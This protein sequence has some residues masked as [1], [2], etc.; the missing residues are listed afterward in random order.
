MIKNHADFKRQLSTKGTRLTTLALANGMV[1]GRIKIG[2]T[3]HIR[4]ADTTGV[5]LITDEELGKTT[6]GSFLGFDKASD[7][8]FEGDIATNTK[9]GYSYRVLLPNEKEAT[10]E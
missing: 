1:E 10:N 7:W 9:F 6:N 8:S 5:Y 4:K 2:A 3:R